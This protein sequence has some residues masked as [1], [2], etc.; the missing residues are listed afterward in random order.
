[1]TE[2]GIDVSNWNTVTNWSAVQGNGISF[3]SIKATESISYASPALAGQTNASR[4]AGVTPGGYHFARSD[5]TPE[6]QAQ[7]FASECRAHA[8]LLPGAFVPMLDLEAAELR[9]TAD[10][11]ASRFITA[12]RVYSGQS[13]IAVYSNLDWFRTVLHPAQWADDN[14][15]L[16]IADWNGNPGTPSWTHPR[17][18]IHQHTDSGTVPGVTGNVDRN[19]TVAPFTVAELTVGTTAVLPPASA[20]IT[21]GD[22][23]FQFVCNTATFTPSN[24]NLSDHATTNPN[25]LLLLGGGY[26]EPATWAD[27]QAKDKTY[28]GDGTGSVLGLGAANYAKYVDLDSK[29]RARDAVLSG[30]GSAGAAGAT[31]AEVAEVVDAAFAGHDATLTYHAITG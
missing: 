25:V 20:P 12:F 13:K 4:A 27:V 19:A 29:V 22:I 31:K 17:L 26:A 2:Y 30:L 18:A 21:P 5:T 28:G 16:W 1:M 6:A 3:V 24:G 14:V 23:M 15:F 11:F 9:G 8:L 7:Y 10:A